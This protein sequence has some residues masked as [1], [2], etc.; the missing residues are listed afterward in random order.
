MVLVAA[1]TLAG[2]G[3]ES[4]KS[5]PKPTATPSP[6]APAGVDAVEP[7]KPQK[8]AKTPESAMEYG[9]Y[10]AL[11]VQ[12]AIETRDSR[13]VSAEAFD[14][15]GC[16]NCVAL[17]KQVDGLKSD[18]IWQLSD[19]LELGKFRAVPLKGGVRVTGSFVYPAVSN[20]EASGKVRRTGTPAPYS[21]WVDLW[22]VE[23][24]STW[25]VL[26]FIYKRKS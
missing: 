6:T 15:T 1:V 14:Q 4:P 9:R 23:K 13:V 12:Y 3:E 8:L 21:Y 25:R 5:A 26:D 16:S 19:P 18:G 24:Q 2:C 17:A 22:W 10:F 7:T 20:V 11:L